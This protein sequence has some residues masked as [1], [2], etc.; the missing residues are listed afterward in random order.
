MKCGA[1]YRI[2]VPNEPLA[3]YQKCIKRRNKLIQ[4][5]RKDNEALA[6]E[7]RLL[8]MKIRKEKGL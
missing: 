5:L 4:R 6:K 8:Q 3:Q 1:G 7:N 2:V